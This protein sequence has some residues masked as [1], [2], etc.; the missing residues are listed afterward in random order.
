MRIA[1][2]KKII[3]TLVT[4]TLL[5]LSVLSYGHTQ[6]CQDM[7][8]IS[9]CDGSAGRYICKSGDFSSCYCKKTA[10]MDLQNIQGCC[11]WHGGVFKTTDLNQVICNDGTLS[12]ICSYTVPEGGF[13]WY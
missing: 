7:G 8:G 10:V 13:S 9:Y 5:F 12:E 1:N 2:M 6:C 3:I 4:N 11:T